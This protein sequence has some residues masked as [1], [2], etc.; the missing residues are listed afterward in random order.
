MQI[1][2]RSHGFVLKAAD[3]ELLSV[4]VVAVA[5]KSEPGS[6]PD[7]EADFQGL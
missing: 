4:E 7:S 3:V 6:E 1:L 2:L 5:I